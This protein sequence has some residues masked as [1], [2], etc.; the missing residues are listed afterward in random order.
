MGA[1]AA[2]RARRPAFSKQCWT[3]LGKN[4]CKQL[5]GARRRL[6][7]RL[8]KGNKRS[9]ISMGSIDYLSLVPISLCFFIITPAL[10]LDFLFGCA[11]EI[12][13]ITFVTS[14]FITPRVYYAYIYSVGGSGFKF[15]LVPPA[16]AA[17]G[18]GPKLSQLAS[19]RLAWA[20]GRGGYSG[21][22]RGIQPATPRVC[23]LQIIL[24]GWFLIIA[25]QPL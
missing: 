4:G 14:H 22:L 2:P 16:P 23:L 17:A 1:S 3:R 8:G 6:R 12:I 13:I 19:H 5:W 24:L 7:R 25:A 10:E 15:G 21:C 20:V 9:L 11:L 18:A